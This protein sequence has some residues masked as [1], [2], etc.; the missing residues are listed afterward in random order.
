LDA[1]VISIL[2]LSFG[3]LLI[4]YLFFQERLIEEGSNIQE[5]GRKVSEE[6]RHYK[7][8]MEVDIKQISKCMKHCKFEQFKV[9]MMMLDM[10]VK[11]KGASVSTTGKIN[12]FSNIYFY[13]KNLEEARE[14]EWKD[15]PVL[16]VPE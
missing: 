5:V 14:M 13:D 10:G 6:I 11:I 4:K 3:L 12:P 7:Q 1:Y 2:I 15:I 8:C 9:L 16:P